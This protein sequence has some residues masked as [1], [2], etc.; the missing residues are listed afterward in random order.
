VDKPAAASEFNKKKFKG[1]FFVK[2]L[3]NSFYTTGLDVDYDLIVA[4]DFL[5]HI[6]NPSDV[7]NKARNITKNKAGFL[8][9]VPNWRMGHQFI[10]RGLFDFDNWVY[11]CKIH[12]WN[13]ESVDGSDLRCQ[14]IPKTATEELLRI[15]PAQP[16]AWLQL[17]SLRDIAGDRVGAAAALRLS[18]LSGPFVPELMAS[19]LMLA[20]RL[21]DDLGPET[22]PLAYRQVRLVQAH[23]P[24]Q[25]ASLSQHSEM[26]N[27]LFL[28]TNAPERQGKADYRASW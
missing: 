24:E 28:A 22:L 13:V 14:R 3:M 11:F 25:Y 18:I 26:T 15:S 5:E 6:A 20:G 19:R 4:N 12:G 27:L 8:V 7:L 16:A 1:S 17:A 9:S 21:L 10:Y 23:L 2:D